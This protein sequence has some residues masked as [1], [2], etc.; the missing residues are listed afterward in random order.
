MDSGQTRRFFIHP[1]SN[2]VLAQFICPLAAPF[3]RNAERGGHSGP[4]ESGIRPVHQIH[5]PWRCWVESCQRRGS[6]RSRPCAPVGVWTGSP[7]VF[8]RGITTC[9]PAIGARRRLGKRDAGCVCALQ[10]NR[11]HHRQGNRRACRGTHK[12]ILRADCPSVQHECGGGYHVC[13]LRLLVERVNVDCE[14]KSML[15]RT[16]WVCTSERS[17]AAL[18]LISTWSAV[19]GHRNGAVSKNAIAR[20]GDVRD[21][22]QNQF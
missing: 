19:S 7:A 9:L 12:G 13:L 6:G 4:D 1:H 5:V 16:V 17:D 10:L 18:T 3:R 15:S 8:K 21:E 14:K 20:G 2:R 22:A 11:L